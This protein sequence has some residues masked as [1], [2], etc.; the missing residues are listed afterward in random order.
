M[1]FPEEA[2]LTTAPSQRAPCETTESVN[3]KHSARK[4]G[5]D[6]SKADLGKNFVDRALNVLAM[7]VDVVHAEGKL[8][9]NTTLCALQLFSSLLSKLLCLPGYEIIKSEYR[10]GEMSNRRTDSATLR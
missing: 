9:L 7:C 4:Y 5:A 8:V 2:L 1:H 10:A 6:Q 3:T